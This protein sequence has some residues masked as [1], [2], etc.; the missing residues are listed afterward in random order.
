MKDGSIDDKETDLI[1]EKLS[2]WKE[3]DVA[4]NFDLILKDQL[5][6]ENMKI[7]VKQNYDFSMDHIVEFEAM[8]IKWCNKFA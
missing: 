2:E 4:E 5:T 8:M 7:P 3:G 1:L 6:V